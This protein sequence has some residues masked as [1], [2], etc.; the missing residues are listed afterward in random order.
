MKKIILNIVA[1]ANYVVIA[2]KNVKLNI[3]KKIISLDVM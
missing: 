3:G 1:N 2:L